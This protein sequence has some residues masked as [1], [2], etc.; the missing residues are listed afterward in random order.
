VNLGIRASRI[1]VAIVAGIV[2]SAAF[3]LAGLLTMVGLAAYTS[4]TWVAARLSKRRQPVAWDAEGGSPEMPW[5]PQE[6]P[7]ERQLRE[8]YVSRRALPVWA[9]ASRREF[10]EAKRKAVGTC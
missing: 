2:V 7:R 10:A 8:R 3:A 9:D 4:W 6:N 5:P 1:I